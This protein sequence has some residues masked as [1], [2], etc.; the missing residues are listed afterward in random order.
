MQLCAFVGRGQRIQTLA[1]G[2][3]A[4]LQTCIEREKK[5][6]VSETGM[7]EHGMAQ[8]E[9]NTCAHVP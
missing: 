3:V 4:R 2:E 7:Q 8:E 5:E 9:P 6:M 1:H